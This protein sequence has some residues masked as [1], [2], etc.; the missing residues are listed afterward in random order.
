MSG[1]QVCDDEHDARHR[2]ALGVERVPAGPRGEDDLCVLVVIDL[3]DHEPTAFQRAHDAVR[4]GGGM[5]KSPRDPRHDQCRSA[6]VEIHHDR[7]R[8][9]F[10]IGQGCHTSDPTQARLSSARRNG[11]YRY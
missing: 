7:E 5:T 2:T 11:D 6:T 8:P 9:A 1:E 10:G 4:C 3:A